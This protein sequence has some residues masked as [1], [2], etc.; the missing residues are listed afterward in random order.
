M[1][2]TDELTV[3]V[4]IDV[5][6]REPPKL[7]I[8][9]ALR[10]FEVILLGYFPVPDQ[11]EPALIKHEYEAEAGARLER[12]AEKGR[13]D[14]TEVLVFTHDVE[15]TIDRVADQ[16]ECDVVL[17]AGDTDHIDRVLVPIRG[18]ANIERIISVVAGLLEGSDA[19]ATFFHAVSD[20]SD[21][22]QGEFL[23]RGTV[24]RLTDYGIGTDRVDWK[25]SESGDPSQEIITIADAF[26]IVVLG[27]TEPSLT[28]R[29]IG[30]FL[31][32]VIDQL[33]T[34]ALIVRDIE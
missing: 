34:P 29:I 6:E 11:A 31:S 12:V 2:P 7:D 33:E 13:G 20:E 10:P 5:S 22:N 8:L 32:G 28:E 18:D 14:L 21:V 19:T 9:D 17:T 15:A 27:E 24:D 30:A 4:P 3:L 25:L 16:H 1:P 23:L 26:D